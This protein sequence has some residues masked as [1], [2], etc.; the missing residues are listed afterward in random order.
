MVITRHL[1]TFFAMC[2]CLI[3]AVSNPFQ[4]EAIYKWTPRLPLRFRVVCCCYCCCCCCRQLTSSSHLSLSSPSVPRLAHQH[5]LQRS[6]CP[7]VISSHIGWS[8]QVYLFLL[9]WAI[10]VVQS[11]LLPHHVALFLSLSVSP[12]TF[13]CAVVWTELSVFP[14]RFVRHK[15]LPPFPYR[16]THTTQIPACIE[17]Q[18]Y[19]DTVRLA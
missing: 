6:C 4:D 17:K 2:R 14:R 3:S 18:C 7:S 13:N 8:A 15:I 10:N 9:I 16:Y 1:H 12:A 19:N 11:G 5:L